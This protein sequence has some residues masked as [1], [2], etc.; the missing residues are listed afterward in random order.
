MIDFSLEQNFNSK[1]SLLVQS[2]S[3]TQI[4]SNDKNEEK[5]KRTQVFF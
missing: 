4:P 5:K 1:A 3:D 2:S